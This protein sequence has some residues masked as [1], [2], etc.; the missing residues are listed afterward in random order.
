MTFKLNPLYTSSHGL[1]KIFDS[2][3]DN[4]STNGCREYLTEKLVA[5]EIK[6]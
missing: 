4:F 5:N 2:C 3:Y 6:K 1:L